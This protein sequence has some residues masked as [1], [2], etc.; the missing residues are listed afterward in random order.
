MIHLIRSCKIPF[1]HHP[2]PALLVELRRGRGGAE[3]SCKI[4]VARAYIRIHPGEYATK[5][6]K[7]FLKSC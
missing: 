7:I 1:A 5:K 4:Y 3:R 6:I 2:Y